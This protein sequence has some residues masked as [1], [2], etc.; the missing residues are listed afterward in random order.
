MVQNN[1]NSDPRNTIQSQTVIVMYDVK[2]TWQ[3][4]LI[5]FFQSISCVSWLKITNIS[6][7]ISVPII[8][9]MM[10]HNSEYK[11]HG[12]WKNN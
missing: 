9:A 8:R 2:L 6:G 7:T 5:K 1:C 3:L 12:K 10:F 11:Y 4:P